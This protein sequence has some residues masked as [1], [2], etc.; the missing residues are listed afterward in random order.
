MF[1]IF[2]KTKVL[3]CVTY[4]I[5]G[6]LKAKVTSTIISHCLHNYQGLQK[7][8]CLFLVRATSLY[9]SLFCQLVS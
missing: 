2:V 6:F 8:V 7:H 9:K 3:Q 4:H 5:K 1:N